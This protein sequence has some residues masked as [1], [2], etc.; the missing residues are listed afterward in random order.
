MRS[1]VL[2]AVGLILAGCQETNRTA[3]VTSNTTAQKNEVSKT[4]DRKYTLRY[5]VSDDQGRPRVLGLNF[6]DEAT[7]RRGVQVMLLSEGAE[8]EFQKVLNATRE[9]KVIDPI[10]LISGW[11]YITGDAPYVETSSGVTAQ[12]EG[13]RMAVRTKQ[14]ET[15]VLLFESKGGGTVSLATDSKQLIAG[16]RIKALTPAN[17]QRQV[18]PPENMSADPDQENDQDVKALRIQIEQE[19]LKWCIP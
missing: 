8:G 16:Q 6:Q 18:S 14:D 1:L 11:L 3:F 5:L 19:R 7:R 9:P 4:T 15:T 10:R 13:S 17:G 2:V 12:A